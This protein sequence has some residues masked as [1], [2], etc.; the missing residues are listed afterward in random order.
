MEK[1]QVYISG[2]DAVTVA[3][4]KRL[5]SYVSPRF[6]VLSNI[7]A[8][9]GEVK[10]KVLESNELAKAYPVVMLLD[11]DQG[12]AP[13]LKSKLLQGNTQSRHFLMN[14]SV[15]EAEAWLM[16]DRQGFSSFFGIDVN[17]IPVSEMQKQGGHVER[18][19]MNFPYKSS[20][21][22]THELALLSSKKEIR[23][24][25]GVSDLNGPKKGKE[26]NDAIV[27]FIEN[28]W[29]IEAALPNSDSLQRMVRRLQVLLEDYSQ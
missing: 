16:A 1:I 21:M 11:L 27:P 15:D 19:E 12:C 17:A 28:N 22:L 14:I 4:I 20:L 2:E 25:V 3:V 7:P 23:Q 5:L 24:K 8:R 13:E 29:D 18:R 10:S 9:G 26:Y 6:V